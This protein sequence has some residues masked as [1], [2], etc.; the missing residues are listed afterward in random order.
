MLS[1]VLTAQDVSLWKFPFAGTIK[2]RTPKVHANGIQS[3]GIVISGTGCLHRRDWA[4]PVSS[5]IGQI[6]DDIE[7]AG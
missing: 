1:R 2:V 5:A 7:A 3:S 4:A 6:A